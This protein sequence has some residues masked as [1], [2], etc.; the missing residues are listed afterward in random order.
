MAFILASLLEAGLLH[1][2]ILTVAGRNLGD[3][4]AEPALQDENLVWHPAPAESWDT[5]MLRPVSAPFH[6]EAT[7]GL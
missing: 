4:A 6:A 1:R 7:C 2:D 3:Y 5:S